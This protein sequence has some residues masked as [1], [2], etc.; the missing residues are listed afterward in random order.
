MDWSTPGALALRRA[1]HWLAA[2]RQHGLVGDQTANELA[3]VLRTSVGER[4]D[5]PDDPLFVIM[6]CGPTA[7]GKS[8]LINALA[9][10]EISA[11]GL[12]ATTSGA[13]VFV[14][15]Q[16]DPAR[17]F[18]YGAALGGLVAEP[19]RLIRHQSATLR[20]VALVDTP[21]IDSVLRQHRELTAELVHSADLVLFVTSPQKYKN[22]EGA[23][24][25]RHQRQ[26]RAIAFVLNKWDRDE[27]GIQYERRGEIATDF[28]DLLDREGFHDPRLFTISTLEE[29]DS[30]SGLDVLRSWIEEAF[31]ESAVSYIRDRRHT[32]AW[33]RVRAAIARAT[34]SP[35]DHN[36]FV[37][38]S[39][40]RLKCAQRKADRLLRTETFALSLEGA[41]RRA[42]PQTPG[43]LGSWLTTVDRGSR[44]LSSVLAT[45]R[46]SRIAASLTGGS[47]DRQSDFGRS[48][49]QLLASTTDTL[50]RE[51]Q[52]RR[53]PPGAIPGKWGDAARDLADALRTVPAGVVAEIRDAQ[54]KSSPRRIVGH[55]AL[56]MIDIA[57]AAVFAMALW[58]LGLGLVSG[59]YASLELLFNIAALIIV[60]LLIGQFLANLFFPRLDDRYRE[61]TRRRVE[62]LVTRAFDSAWSAVTEQVLAA[63]RLI[64]EGD[65]LRA[66]IDQTLAA[67]NRDRGY[68]QAE[69]GRLFGRTAP[70]IADAG[71]AAADKAGTLTQPAHRPSPK[72]D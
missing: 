24:W 7:V 8:R 4:L 34:P 5:Q 56:L 28:V 3:D 49:V 15:E 6:L 23:R 47:D 42:L 20:H 37:A 59:E 41:G 50:V 55:A 14:H 9:R 13:V 25:I 44:A 35:L 71:D 63:A 58:R 65:G 52:I 36:E 22:M 61:L 68:D 46:W 38:I 53:F 21:D 19:A 66:D 33:A 27:L 62:A 30:D 60:L 54:L 12:S 51:M 11:T 69:L 43:L 32:A 31:D 10:A 1:E 72:F 45:I 70:A 57:I 26:Q 17:L 16:D 67:L 2:L 39:Q 29:A 18:E 64:N 48:A 40:R